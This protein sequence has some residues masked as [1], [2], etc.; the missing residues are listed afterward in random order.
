M[1]QKRIEVGDRLRDTVMDVNAQRVAHV[2]A[3][4]ILLAAEKKHQGEALATELADFITNVYGKEPALE[5]FFVSTGIGRDRKKAVIMRALEGRVSETLLHTILVLNDHDRLELLRQILVELRGLLDEKAG[6]MRISVRSAVELNAEQQERIKQHLR[7]DLHKEPVLEITVDPGLLGGMV[8]R[9][10]DL[11]YDHSVRAR[12]ETIRNQIIAR[13]SH[14][15]QTGRD[16]FCT[17]NG[18]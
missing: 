8:I 6:R 5:T 3:E 18:N 9:V 1:D 13:S 2:Y 14:E 11:V 12:L 17:A 7:S 15:I 4:A 16:R 10:G